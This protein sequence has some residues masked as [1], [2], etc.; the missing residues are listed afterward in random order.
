MAAAVLTAAL[1]TAA[2]EEPAFK[3]V[4]QGEDAKK[5]AELEKRIGELEAAD[6]YAE[7]ARAA[8]ELAE[9]RARVQGAGHWQAADARRQVQTLEKLA[10]LP[11]EQRAGWRQAARGPVTAGRLEQQARYGEA[12]ALRQERLR[13]CR[14]VLGE[15]HPDTAHSYNNVAFNLNA[16]GKHA[17]AGPLFAKALAIY[18]KALGEDHPDTARSYNNVAFNLGAQGKHAE[19]GPL[20]HKALAIYRKALGEEHPHTAASYNNVAF[21]LNAQGKYAEAGPLYQKALD[22]FRK[23]L[24]E[25]H[26]HTATSY[27][28]VAFNLQAQGKYAEAGPLF[29]KALAIFRKVLGEEHPHTARSYNNVAVNLDAQ[30]RHAEAERQWRAAVA[31]FEVSRLRLAPSGFDRAAAARIRPHDG[32][33]LCLAR[34]G[35]G[36]DAWQAAE[37]GLARGLLDDLALPDGAAD[38]HAAERRRRA[39][40][41]ERL[42]AL[43][44]PLL[45][46]EKLSA[47][48]RKERDRLLGERDE[49]LAEAGA[50][51]ARLAAERV[52]PPARIQGQL[53]ADAALVL[54]LDGS[55]AG[56]AVETGGWHWGCVVRRSGT[57]AAAGGV[58]GTGR[59]PRRASRRRRGRRPFPAK[60]P[61]P[62]A[63]STQPRR[64]GSGRPA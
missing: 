46:A 41:L 36:L 16:L 7:A 62:S 14:Q 39:A 31:A 32:L 53:P 10:G 18:R 15:D 42:D 29:Q 56:K 12:L 38:P 9:L 57:P 21:N 1:V 50:E 8:R 58:A 44:L 5:A 40:R 43:L 35:K 54:W 2:A 24:G 26:P 55:P 11:A 3:R 22:I 51:A 59:P 45:T 27:N 4:L 34:Q 64:R 6:N 17:E 63:G 49:L 19:A 30:G 25:D 28:N 13:W 48:R 52:L 23:L 37:A 61:L 20:F 33:A 47:D 60:G